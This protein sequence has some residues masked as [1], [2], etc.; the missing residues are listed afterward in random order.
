MGKKMKL[1]SLFKNKEANHSWQWPS[2]K[3]PKTLSFRARAGDAIFKTVN[4][5][6]FD[7]SDGVE[8]P[9]SWFTNSSE[10]PSFSSKS[11]D[12]KA[13]ESSVEVIVRGAQSERLFFEPGDDTRSIVKEVVVD[14]GE[15]SG[16]GG[17]Y[18]NGFSFEESEVVAVE[19]DDP[20]ED[21]RRSMEEMVESHGLRSWECLEELLGWY[22]KANGKTNHGYIVGAFIDLLV[23]MAV[24]A[25]ATA[26]AS[27]SSS[28]SVSTSFSSAACSFSSAESPLSSLVGKKKKEK[29]I[30]EQDEHGD[31]L[32][33]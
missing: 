33:S 32:I 22:L 8:T 29:E 17:D 11:E 15:S 20:A 26:V 19:S 3:Q 27:S 13:A 1:P 2:C 23:A 16:G 30:D 12:S 28:R 6:F 5:V 18:G 21:F 25:A 31:A 9:E 4:S 7:F 24:E 14:G 10:S